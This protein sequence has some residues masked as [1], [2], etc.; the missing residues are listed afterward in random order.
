LPAKCR[1]GTGKFVSERREARGRRGSSR[2]VG[3]RV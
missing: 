3:K 2:A 1:D